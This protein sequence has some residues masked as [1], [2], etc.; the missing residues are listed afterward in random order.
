M[1]LRNYDLNQWAAVPGSIAHREGEHAVATFGD[2]SA[3]IQASNWIGLAVFGRLK[4]SPDPGTTVIAE[5]TLQLSSGKYSFTNF[6]RVQTKV[7][8]VSLRDCPTSMFLFSILDRQKRDDRSSGKVEGAS[9]LDTWKRVRPDLAQVYGAVTFAEHAEDMVLLA[10]FNRIGVKSPSYLDIGAN[11]PY[12]IS[13]TAL[14]YLRG[15]RGINVEAN[16]TALAVFEAERPEDIN[17]TIG[18]APT[19]GVMKFYMVSDNSTLNS[20][21][22]QSIAYHASIN[23]DIKITNMIDIEV[24][25]IDAIVDN[26]ANGAYPDL[27]S[28][29]IELLDYDVLVSADFTKSRPKVICVEIGGEQRYVEMLRNRG[30]HLIYKPFANAIFIHEDYVH[31]IPWANCACASAH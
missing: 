8:I 29:D 9:V 7:E 5:V 17:V 15:C 20:F 13:N 12:N 30:Y 24:D 23:P 6:E 19:K 27:L 31:L 1:H 25:T 22:P 11:H 14:F 2:L 16:P 26:Y 21:N 3:F 28:I 18:V 10:I 4:L